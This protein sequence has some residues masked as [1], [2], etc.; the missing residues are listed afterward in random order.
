MKRTGALARV[1][2]AD[3]EPGVRR[4]M[5]TSLARA[6]FEVTAVDDGAPAIALA[7]SAFAI[8]LVDLNMRTSGLAVIRHYKERYGASVY[9]AVL[10]GEDDEDTRAACLEAGADEVFCKP[11]PASVLRHRL[12]EVALALRAAAGGERSA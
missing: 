5:E 6:G 9:C 8:V 11:L 2:L 3:D 12:T 7:D 4:A 10:S 1:L